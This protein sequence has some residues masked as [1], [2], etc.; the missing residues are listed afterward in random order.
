MALVFFKSLGHFVLGRATGISR[1]LQQDD[2][3]KNNIS[4]VLG[5]KP[6]TFFS[7]DLHYSL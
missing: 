4:S 2:E 6:V 1:C 5:P 7:I 3:H